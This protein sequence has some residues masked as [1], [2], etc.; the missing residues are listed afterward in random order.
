MAR[1]RSGEF[2]RR[3]GAGHRD[4]PQKI[5]TDG[6]LNIFYLAQFDE[7]FG[8]SSITFIATEV[9]AGE[10]NTLLVLDN[11]E[12]HASGELQVHIVHP[13]FVAYPE[14]EFPLPDLIDSFSN[15]EA[16]FPDPETG[17]QSLGSG[18]VVLLDWLPD[19]RLS[20]AFGDVRIFAE[21]GAELVDCLALGEFQTNVVPNL[22]FCA[23][24]CHNGVGDGSAASPDY[25]PDA[26]ATMDLSKLDSDPAAACREARL[27]I[28]P[29]LPEN[30]QILISTDPLGTQVHPYRFEGD[31]QAY[32]SFAAAVSPWITQEGT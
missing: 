31:K 5:Y 22:T 32:D 9:D 29:G 7:N 6:A 24:T 23:E 3:P 28:A 4:D 27:R 1:E 21:N 11:I 16:V 2:T 19:S 18:G 15:V 17:S 14:D 26:Q 13:L 8:G 12:V 20:I 30:S 10:G 25:P